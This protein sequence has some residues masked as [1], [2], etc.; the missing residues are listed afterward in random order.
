MKS[1]VTYNFSVSVSQGS[2]FVFETLFCLIDDAKVRTKT[3]RAKKNINGWEKV[4]VFV[5]VFAFGGNYG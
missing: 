1:V 3:R 4:G 2:R 5:G